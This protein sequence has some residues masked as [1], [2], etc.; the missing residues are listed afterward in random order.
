MS[1]TQPTYEVPN[2]E[3]AVTKTYSMKMLHIGMVSDLA[4]SKG[5][6]QG[7]EVRT[8]IERSFR[9]ENDKRLIEM[10]NLTQISKD[11]LLDRAIGLLHSRINE[12][13]SSE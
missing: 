8:A 9:I 5:T 13:Q 12:I 6:S 3:Y 1:E 2:Q 10:A 4:L 11:E 7:R